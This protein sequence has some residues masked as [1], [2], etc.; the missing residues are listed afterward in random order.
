MEETAGPR[1][2]GPYMI[3]GKLNDNAYV[4]QDLE[5]ENKYI[6]ANVKK[7]AKYHEEDNLMHPENVEHP[8]TCSR[9]NYRRLTS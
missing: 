3:H 4:L 1:F 6:V 2:E 7:I 9:V 8:C 5:N